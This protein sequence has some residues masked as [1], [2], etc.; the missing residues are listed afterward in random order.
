MKFVVDEQLSPVLARWLEARGHQAAHVMAL[1]LLSTPDRRIAEIAV[2]RG[3]IMV[4]K[5]KDYADWR[6]TLP[7]LR[8]LWVRIGD[9][10]NRVLLADLEKEV[11]ALLK[12]FQDAFKPTQAKA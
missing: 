7:G 10:P 6:V 3:A 12:N 4:T 8:V 5:D 11:Q 9:V 2:A 1:G